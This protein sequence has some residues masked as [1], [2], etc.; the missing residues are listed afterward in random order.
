MNP[1]TERELVDSYIRRGYWQDRTLGDFISTRAQAEGD[2]IALVDQRDALTYR[3]LDDAAGR[4]AGLLAQ[5][6]VEKGDRVMLQMKNSVWHVVSFLGIAKAGA[7]P[8]MALCAH[9]L[10]ELGS[11]AERAEPTA[12]IV[13]EAHQGIDYPAMARE[14]QARFPGMK[15]IL[16]FD[17]IVRAARQAS[18]LD[19]AAIAARRPAFTDIGL[20]TCSGGSTN[21]PKLIPRRHADYL[22]DA[23][24]FAA[25]LGMNRNDAFMIALPASHNFVL[26]NPGI[27]GTLSV[28]G[29]V[30]LCENPS[31]DE[32]L[33][34]IEEHRV[35]GISLVPAVLSA[36]LETLS[37]DDSYDLSSWRMTLVGGSVLEE[38]LARKAMLMLPSTLHQVFGTAEGINFC[39]AADDPEEV[40]IA[41]Q[42]KAISEADEWKIVDENLNEVPRG[43]SGE[44]IARGPYTIQHYYR[45]PE[46][47]GSFTDDGFYRTG[48]RAHVAPNGY[49]VVEGRIT[50]QINRGGEK[51]VPSELE[52]YLAELPS[53]EEVQVVGVP[54]ELLGQRVCAFAIGGSDGFSP[55]SA[56]SHLASLG[57]ASHKRIDQ[58]ELIDMWPLTAVGKI[59]RKRL[60]E[61][62][63]ASRNQTNRQL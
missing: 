6:G 47:E 48:D 39:T 12:F 5:K 17:D 59:D 38:Q 49:L 41:S 50:D 19:A 52:G 8:I 23:E 58:V 4:V 63:Q 43:A 10:R 16:T 60:V 37:W 7:I 29:T 45:A 33:P 34:M 26:G 40:V 42:G 18:P 36:V 44:L 56:N 62:A 2:R 31:P 13:N 1:V 30:V 24:T 15:T 54:D 27:L 32:I 14:V 28:G 22:Y 46:A 51:I 55:A 21:I 3:E 11:F 25:F 53:I 35:T 20:L 57:V 61:W 9:R